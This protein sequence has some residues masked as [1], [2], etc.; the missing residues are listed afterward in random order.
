MAY[1]GGGTSLGWGFDGG[2][3]SSVSLTV[4]NT[5]GGASLDFDPYSQL[6]RYDMLWLPNNVSFYADGKLLYNT[7]KAVPNIT[8]NVWFILYGCGASWCSPFQYTAPQTI[9]V[10]SVA[11]TPMNSTQPVTCS[12][13][14]P[15]P[16]YCDQGAAL[17][18]LWRPI[19]TCLTPPS[20]QS[21]SRQSSAQ[22]SSFLP[23]EISLQ[24]HAQ[25]ASG[26][27]VCHSH[28]Y[29]Q[30]NGAVVLSLN[31]SVTGCS[32][33]PQSCQQP[34]AVGAQI[35]GPSA[36]HY[37]NISAT[38]QAGVGSGVV[39][40]FSILSA[41]PPQSNRTMALGISGDQPRQAYIVVVN[42]SATVTLPFD[43]STGSH[44]YDI[45]WAWNNVSVL[46]DGQLLHRFTQG[47]DVQVPLSRLP[48]AVSLEPCLESWCSNSL[49]GLAGGDVSASVP[50]NSTAVLSTVTFTAQGNAATPSCSPPQYSLVWKEDFEGSQLDASRWTVYNNCTHQDEEELY[51]TQ[52]ASVSN[53]MLSLTAFK[54]ATPQYG[55][56]GRVYYYGSSWVDT[57]NATASQVRAKLMHERI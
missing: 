46:A 1:D 13:P 45:I 36:A 16:S 52:G 9:E 2:K 5:Y 38:L 56:N 51:V 47:V 3:G 54:F 28:V 18:N 14:P 43:A 37:G 49:G 20:A 34:L 22:H 7:S 40:W 25:A 57:A 53:G 30:S 8:L 41:L 44:R 19:D 10:A 11:Y 27:A 33:L 31:T 17:Q 55:Q 4:G 26:Y 12:D 42:A 32:N 15:P 29:N 50:A 23:S 6:H 48:V 21:G 24:Q 39:T 35:I